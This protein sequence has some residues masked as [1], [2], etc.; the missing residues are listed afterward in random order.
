M[1]NNAL[2]RVIVS[3]GVV[4]TIAGHAG[5][6][7]YNDGVGSSA[8]FDWIQGVVVDPLGE[9]ALVVSWFARPECK[10]AERRH[11]VPPCVP[12]ASTTYMRNQSLCAILQSS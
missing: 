12:V 5:V 3:S 1:N 10:G 2:R 6:S 9:F 11:D 8:G 7:V 4:S